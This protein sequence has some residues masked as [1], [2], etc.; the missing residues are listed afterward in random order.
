MERM[1]ETP[2]IE[3][4]KELNRTSRLLS[5]QRDAFIEHIRNKHVRGMARLFSESIAGHDNEIHLANSDYR[6]M[7]GAIRNALAAEDDIDLE[8]R[9]KAGLETLGKTAMP[10]SSNI[11]DRMA[12]LLDGTETSAGLR[13]KLLDLYRL[14]EISYPLGTI[15]TDPAGGENAFL[16]GSSAVRVGPAK[17]KGVVHSMEFMPEDGDTVARHVIQDCGNS[18]IGQSVLI[19][20]AVMAFG[21][22]RGLSSFFRQRFANRFNLDPSVELGDDHR[23]SGWLIVARSRGRLAFMLK[24]VGTKSESEISAA[25]TDASGETKTVVQPL[26]EQKDGHVLTVR[27]WPRPERTHAHF[28][29]D[30]EVRYDFYTGERAADRPFGTAVRTPARST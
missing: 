15:V 6:L 16:P 22:G 17:A 3:D 27:Q 10:S 19:E 7:L 29:A 8:L 18:Y 20:D 4:L 26:A 2:A 5:F 12:K 9:W 21:K 23:L 14:I 13:R 30:P 28:V 24:H 11:M 25:M 1:I